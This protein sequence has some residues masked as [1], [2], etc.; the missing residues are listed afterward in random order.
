MN[1][2][3]RNTISGEMLL[4][5]KKSTLRNAIRLNNRYMKSKRYTR[6]WIFSKSDPQNAELINREADRD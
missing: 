2:V 1:K 3:A 6:A 4:A 5:D